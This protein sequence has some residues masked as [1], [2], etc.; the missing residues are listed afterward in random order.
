MP[1]YPVVLGLKGDSSDVVP[2]GSQGMSIPDGL[3]FDPALVLHGEQSIEL[4]KPIPTEGGNFTLKG[5][6][7]GFWNK[8]KGALWETQADMVGVSFEV[9]I[10]T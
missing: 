3:E 4:M 8:G 9:T 7:V 1:T 10:S 5:K 6:T 2:F